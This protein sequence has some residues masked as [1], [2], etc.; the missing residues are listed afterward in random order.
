MRQK[1]QPLIGATHLLRTRANALSA[2]LAKKLKP[3]PMYEDLARK[4]EEV[5]FAIAKTRRLTLSK[6]VE[7]RPVSSS[8]EEDIHCDPAT[9]FRSLESFMDEDLPLQ[10]VPVTVGEFIHGRMEARAKRHAAAVRNVPYLHNTRARISSRVSGRRTYPSVLTST[11][12]PVDFLSG[13][14]HHPRQCDPP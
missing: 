4:C 2:E 11:A 8:D 7:L 9:L 3:R 1:W 10:G 13:D 6:R 12:P 5:G 14:L